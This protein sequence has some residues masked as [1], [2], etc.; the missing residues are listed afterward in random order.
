M[1][2]S[3]PSASWFVQTF[4]GKLK[5]NIFSGSYGTVPHRGCLS[6]K[7]FE[8]KVYVDTSQNDQ[9]YIVAEC[10]WRLPFSEGLKKTDYKIIKIPYT[11]ESSI[12]EIEIWLNNQYHFD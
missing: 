6:I 4:D 7:T 5:T 2:I 3:L 1:S 9:L 8:Y 12:R 11:A 10:Y